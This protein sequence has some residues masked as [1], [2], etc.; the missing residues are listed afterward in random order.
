[1]MK[2]FVSNDPSTDSSPLMVARTNELLDDLRILISFFL[3]SLLH[4]QTRIASVVQEEP[5]V[6][7]VRR[8]DV[9]E[10]AGVV[11]GEVFKGVFPNERDI[12]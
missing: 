8:E 5:A 9:V 1:M 3:N 11:L 12:A 10:L 2:Y 7:F 4:S 6:D